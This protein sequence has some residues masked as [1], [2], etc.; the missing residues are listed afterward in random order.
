MMASLLGTLFV[1]L[2]NM[3]F[4]LWNYVYELYSIESFFY[5][6]YY[7]TIVGYVCRLYIRKNSWDDRPYCTYM[8]A[9]AI[10]SMGCLYT[11]ILVDSLVN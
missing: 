10:I 6:L 11:A 7:L 9:A 2:V 8:F 1:Y 5:N 3:A 4:C